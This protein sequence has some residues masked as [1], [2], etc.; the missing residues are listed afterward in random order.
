MKTE[1][2]KPSYSEGLEARK[3]FEHVMAALFRVPKS[4]VVKKIKEK[5]KKGK[6]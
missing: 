6:N 4:T 1:K 3:E 5:P 2:K